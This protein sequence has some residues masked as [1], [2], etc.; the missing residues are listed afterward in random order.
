MI[1][2]Y[3][4]SVPDETNSYINDFDASFACHVW[5]LPHMTATDHWTL[6][7]IMGTKYLRYG[8]ASV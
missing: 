3:I 5:L 2:S 1:Y 7:G 8:S 6:D 4:V